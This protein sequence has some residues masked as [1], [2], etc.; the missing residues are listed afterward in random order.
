MAKRILV[1]VDTNARAE[2]I[3]PVVAALA[4]DGGG[5]VRLLHVQPVPR[6]HVDGGV[7]PMSWCG[8]DSGDVLAARVLVYGHAQ[9]EQVEAE[10]LAR[11]RELE[12]LLA[13]VVVERSV[14]F[15]EIVEEIAREASEFSADL[16]ALSESR[17]P[18]WR[19]ALARIVDRLRARTSVPVLALSGGAS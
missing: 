17:R 18:W 11:L 19:P 1:P 3:V 9:E 16:V 8:Q 5:T 15:G 14:R 10:T 12:S 13:G 7:H 4:R 2:R 6:T